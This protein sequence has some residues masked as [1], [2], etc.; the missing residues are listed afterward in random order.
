VTGPDVSLPG[1][2]PTPLT[3]PHATTTQPALTAPTD[4]TA[5]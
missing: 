2:H 5:P 4:R 3:T 1:G